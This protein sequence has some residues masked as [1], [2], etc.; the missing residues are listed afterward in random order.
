VINLHD[1]LSDHLKVNS[2]GYTEKP[3]N[4][5]D[6]V[7]SHYKSPF[8]SHFKNFPEERSMGRNL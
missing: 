2:D 1:K 4:K 5:F 3:N 7:F 6:Y 8:F